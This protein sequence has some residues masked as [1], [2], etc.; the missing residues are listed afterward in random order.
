MSAVVAPRRRPIRWDRVLGR[1]LFLAALA[2]GG[3]VT[4]LPYIWM[5][6][7]SFKPQSELFTATVQLVPS[8]PTLDNY[9]VALNREPIGRFL[10]NSTVVALGETLGVLVT[11]VLAGYSFGRLKFWGRDV[12]FLMVLGTMMIPSQVTLIPSFII[13]KW[14]GWLNTYQ[15]LIVPRIVTGF[16]VFLMRQFFLSIPREIEDAARID[17][18][19]RFGVLWRVLLPLV[20]PALATLA[21]FTFN[22][23]WNEF[24]WPLVVASTGEMRTIQVAISSFR[25]EDTN[26][27]VIMA[28][29]TL[30]ALPVM[31]VYLLLQRYFVKG[32]V[33]SGLKG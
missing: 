19:S 15:G 16:G 7:S 14:L 11:S 32:I 4:L 26:W 29:V 9:A 3:A 25:G 31:V 33:M 6:S 22:N 12:L 24:F 30:A 23:S 18:C 2:L 13:M 28:A 27:G 5:V 8:R 10:F 21:I 17:G 20:T 1:V